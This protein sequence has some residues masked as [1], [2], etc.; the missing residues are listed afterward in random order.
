MRMFQAWAD[1]RLAM[2]RNVNEIGV[3]RSYGEH[4]VGEPA[5]E[6]A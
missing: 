1:V 4:R 5:A 3:R 2:S 6:G